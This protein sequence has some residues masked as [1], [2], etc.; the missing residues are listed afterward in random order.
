[1]TELLNKLQGTLPWDRALITDSLSDEDVD[2]LVSATPACPE[3]VM[4]TIDHNV[5]SG[6]VAVAARQR[7]LLDF[8]RSNSLPFQYGQGIGY[9]LAMET[10]SPGDIIICNGRHA[11]TVGAVG[12][13]GLSLD[14]PSLKAALESGTVALD[15]PLCRLRLEGELTHHVSA[16]D[17]ALH[18]IA[19]GGLAGKL[20]A[21]HG[22]QLSFD[23][24]VTLC[25]LL[26]NA[27]VVSAFFVDE[28]PETDVVCDLS[29]VTPLA[30]LPGDFSEIVPSSRMDGL[31]V[32]QVFIGG[33]CGG[34]I[35]SLRKTAAIWQGKKINKHVRVMVSPATAAIYAQ[36]IDDGLIETLMASGA[37]I[38]NQGCGACWA[39]GQGRCDEREVF[40]TTGSINCANW[41]GKQH[42][43]IYITSVEH[44]A[45]AALTGSLYEN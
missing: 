7:K 2:I 27:G 38:M 28:L 9:Y 36:A 31:R 20:L 34:S 45:R 8:A 24:R 25:N 22:P 6:T 17:L 3:K 43:G 13:I 33:C 30:V 44:A 21:I 18:L 14:A 19:L 29:A 11:A 39:Q 32:N 37:L 10:L 15:A 16:T 40:L 4:V 1:M 5:P 23:Q 42:N 26:A 35:E 12:A 41:A